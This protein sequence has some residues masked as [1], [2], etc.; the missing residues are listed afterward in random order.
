MPSPNTARQLAPAIGAT[1][2]VR[3]E[4][5]QVRCLVLDAKNAYGNVR[6]LVKPVTGDGQQWVDITRLIAPEVRLTHA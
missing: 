1:V 2:T 3:C 5:L 6:L 4:Q